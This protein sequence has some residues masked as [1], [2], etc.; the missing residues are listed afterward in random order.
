VIETETPAAE[1]AAPAAPLPA[2]RAETNWSAWAATAACVGMILLSLALAAA[3]VVTLNATVSHEIDVA[4]WS[5]LAWQVALIGCTLVAARAYGSQPRDVLALR[6]PIQGWR[7]YPLA[8]VTLIGVGLTLGNILKAIDPTAGH[9]DLAPFIKMLASEPVP[10]L[11][12][13]GVGAPIAEELLFRGFLFSAIA[14][15]RLGVVGAGILTSLPFALL[16]PYSVAGVAQVLV[17][18]LVLSF[19]LVRTGSLRVTIVA[20]AVFNTLQA[21]ALLLTGGTSPT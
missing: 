15:T 11:L 19:I 6:P 14:K 2:Y 18:G 16:H 20:H 9:D 12:M 8:C 4:L 17:A 13:V 10:T 5:N 21:L 3:I 7:A 1:P